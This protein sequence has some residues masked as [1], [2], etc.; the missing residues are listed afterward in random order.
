MFWRKFSFIRSTENVSTCHMGCHPFKMDLFW[1]KTKWQ[2]TDW[3]HVC[4]PHP[5]SHSLH[6]LSPGCPSSLHGGGPSPLHTLSN[7]QNIYFP[8][9]TQPD[10]GSQAFSPF[11][12][13]LGQSEDRHCIKAPATVRTPLSSMFSF[14][15][16]AIIPL[17]HIN[18]W[19]FIK[20]PERVNTS[21]Q[22]WKRQFSRW[23]Q[24]TKLNLV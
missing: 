12:P 18:K 6:P 17:M 20:T 15:C 13:V 5:W 1:N 9:W 11:A 10:A 7:A 8:A 23:K 22:I 21:T 19:V 14:R 24:T 4:L 3:A 2:L 16:P